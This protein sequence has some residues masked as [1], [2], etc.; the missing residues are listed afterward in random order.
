MWA[1][2]VPDI[3]NPLNGSGNG[4][5]PPWAT[6]KS[7]VNEFLRLPEQERAAGPV[8]S[9]E[10]CKMQALEKSNEVLSKTRHQVGISYLYI[11]DWVHAWTGGWM[12]RW[13]DGWMED[14][15]RFK[16]GY[17]YSKIEIF[18]IDQGML[19]HFHEKRNA[20]SKQNFCDLVYNS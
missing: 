16:Q 11:G 3:Y 9:W 5:L 13:M 1:K 18:I 14:G 15:R 12:D 10:R 17:W 7:H 20:F 4:P 19:I 2:L 8:R 6:A